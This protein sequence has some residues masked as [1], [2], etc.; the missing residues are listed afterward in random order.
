MTKKKLSFE[1]AQAR[2][3]EIG[4]QMQALSSERNKIT[5]AITVSGRTK[6]HRGTPTKVGLYH[7]S[8]LATAPIGG[9]IGYWDG[10]R[11]IKYKD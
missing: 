9:A 11:W 3:I 6:Y 1:K 2:I 5:A 7:Y 8:S 10:H 4:V